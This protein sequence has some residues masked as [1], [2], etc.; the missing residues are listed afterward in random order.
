MVDSKIEREEL[1]IKNKELANAIEDKVK[2]AKK[3]NSAS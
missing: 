1:E 3:K 2:D